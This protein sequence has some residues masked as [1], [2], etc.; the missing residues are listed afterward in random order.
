MPFDNQGNWYEERSGGGGGGG[1][2]VEIELEIEPRQVLMGFWGLV[3]A[4]FLVWG[5][6]T[7]FFTV[8]ANEEAVILRLGKVNG[9]VGPGFHG[10]IPFGIDKVFKGAVKTVH[11]AEFGYRTIKAGV[12]SSFDR[13]S[14]QVVAEATMLT[15]DQN[16]VMVNWEIRYKIKKL[17]NYLFEVR[18][19]IDTLRAVSEAVMRIEVGDRSV[20]EALTLERTQIENAVKS[21]MQVSLDRFKCGI[22]IVKVNLKNV[23]PPDAVKDAFNAVNRAVQVRNRIVNEAEG[24]RNKKVPAARGQ[25]DRAIKEA[26]GYEIG[27]LNRARGETEAFLSVLE[28]YRK[29]EDITRRRLYLEAMGRALPKAGDFTIIDSDQGGVLKLLDLNSSG[30]QSPRQ[31]RRRGAAAAQRV[32]R[33]GGRR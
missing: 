26:E 6:M 23:D 21:K 8:E 9:V 28:E 19:P 15:G 24:E 32:M 30:A 17:Q 10:K 13:S 33:K 16:L 14:S 27:R 18:D 25:A 1:G 31:L 5:V 11:Q 4:A 3:L 7:S 29:A 20:D 12:K 2:P 22:H